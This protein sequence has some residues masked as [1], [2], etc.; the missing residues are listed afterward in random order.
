MIGVALV[1]L[2][3]GTA[4]LVVG[5]L[6]GHPPRRAGAG[7]VAGAGVSTLAA[8]AVHGRPLAAVVTGLLAAA[9]VAVWVLLRRAE[10]TPALSLAALPSVVLLAAVATPRPSPRRQ[11]A[12]AVLERLGVTTGVEQALLALAV[13]V[14]LLATANAVV[15]LVL[16]AAGPDVARSED[17]LQGGRLIGAVERLIVAG[18]TAA[19]QPGAAALVVAAKAI[20]RFPELSSAARRDRAA[21]AEGDAPDPLARVDA[22][23]EYFLLG[24]LAS[25][26]VALLGGWLLAG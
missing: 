7:V 18:L 22:V 16:V 20:V 23:T 9:A 8:L 13:L 1:L 21:E 17:R 3:V 12:A 15:R 4:D 6:V 5:G 19:G 14:V 25:L 11:P 10:V 2:A 26:G 24:S